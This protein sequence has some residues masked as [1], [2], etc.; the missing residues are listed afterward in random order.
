MTPP[1]PGYACAHTA[2]SEHSVRSLMAC[3]ERKPGAKASG[4]QQLQG[5]GVAGGG[6]GGRVALTDFTEYVARKLLLPECYDDT[7]RSEQGPL[8]LEV[9]S[10]PGGAG[11]GEARRVGARPP[12]LQS[13]RGAPPHCPPLSTHTR[14]AH[15]QSA[16]ALAPPEHMQGSKFFELCKA[17][18]RQQMM[19]DAMSVSHLL[20]GAARPG[21]AALRQTCREAA[22]SRGWKGPAAGRP[23]VSCGRGWAVLG[24]ACDPGQGH[25]SSAD[26][27]IRRQA[28]GSPRKH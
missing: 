14:S 12:P 18:K 7:L 10:G 25:C 24:S 8:L 2:R 15:T 22:H 26:I 23:R 1:P 11:P 4:Q 27:T 3:M 28:R 5:G 21:P 6:G 17:F 13:C 20:A 9:V 16:R 19:V